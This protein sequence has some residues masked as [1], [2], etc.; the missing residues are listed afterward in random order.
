LLL[1]EIVIQVATSEIFPYFLSEKR[2]VMM[3]EMTE[4]GPE[5]SSEKHNYKIAR[6]LFLVFN[7]KLIIFLHS[8]VF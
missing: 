4:N 6:M 3:K 5:T 1:H 8:G 7:K 2:I